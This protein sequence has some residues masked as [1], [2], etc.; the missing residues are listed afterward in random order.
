MSPAW[1][2]WLAR[3]IGGRQEA[4]IQDVEIPMEHAARFAQFLNQD[5][6]IQPVWICPVAAYDSS[7]SIRYIR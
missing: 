6:G 1:L 4:V 5:I 7:A 2:S 3:A